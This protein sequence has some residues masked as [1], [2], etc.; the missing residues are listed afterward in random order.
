MTTDFLYK[1]PKFFTVKKND[2]TVS[3]HELFMV[4]LKDLYTIIFLAKLHEVGEG[5]V[6]LWLHIHIQ[7]MFQWLHH[8]L[9]V[10]ETSRNVQLSWSLFPWRITITL[11]IVGMKE[12]IRG[13]FLHVCPRPISAKDLVTKHLDATKTTHQKWKGRNEQLQLLGS[14]SHFQGFRSILDNKKIFNMFTRFHL[15]LTNIYLWST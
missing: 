13:F 3:Y 11:H 6:K 1:M 10:I 15:R 14:K 9:Q 4:A 12:H 7:R 8:C 2:T 5:G